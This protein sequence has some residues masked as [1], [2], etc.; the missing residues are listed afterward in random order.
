MTVKLELPL[1]CVTFGQQNHELARG[2]T[3]I[4]A[5]VFTISPSKILLRATMTLRKRSSITE[6]GSLLAAECAIVVS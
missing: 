4:I 1:T 2:L 6:H 3:M 5:A